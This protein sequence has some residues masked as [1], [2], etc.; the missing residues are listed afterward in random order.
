MSHLPVGRGRPP[1][2]GPGRVLGG[3]A[4]LRRWLVTGAV[5]L[6]FAVSALVLATTLSTAL[7][8]QAAGIAGLAALLPL[9]IVVPAFLW[10]D[11]YESEPL[12]YLV[13]AF[14][15]GALV[16]ASVSLFLN[17][18]SM[19]LLQAFSPDGQIV[20][21][22]VVAPIVEESSKIIAVVLIWRWARD[23]FD[24]VIDGI[25]Y[26]GLSAAGFAFVENIVYLGQAFQ[27]SGNEGLVAVLL[28]RG[29]M[30]PFA[31]PLFTCAAGAAI[32]LVAHSRSAVARLVVPLLGLAAA[33]GMHALWNMSA[34]LGLDGYVE[35]YLSLQLPL[36]AAGVAFALWSRRR[37]GQLI[38]R[39]LSGYAR[40]GWLTA[41]EVTMLAH[42]PLRRQ[43]RQWAREQGGSQAVAS[44]RAFQ[45]T[46]SE[47]ALLRERM[48]RGSARADALVAEQQALHAL[49]VYRRGYL[50]SSDHKAW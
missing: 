5:V 2:W 9:G 4:L 43:A 30:G 26:A 40:Q 14:G 8:V 50:Y 36:F 48:R 3:T 16:A 15:W 49:G 34:V 18:G 20:T 22:V 47:L 39:H 35:R 44:M 1:Q 24:G 13:F 25:V 28:V 38:A 37:E 12:R 27:E 32:G 46:A 42:L 29:L 17:V 45:D 41:A 10:L 6:L 33:I 7:T 19:A 11:R 21:L 23:E 31:H